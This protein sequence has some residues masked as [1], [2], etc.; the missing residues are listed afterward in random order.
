MTLIKSAQG[1]GYKTNLFFFWLKSPEEAILRIAD[2]VRNG[3][4]NI[5]DDVVRRRYHRGIVNFFSL[6]RHVVDSWYIFDSSNTVPELIA[7]GDKGFGDI[8]N[9]VEL[10]KQFKG[11]AN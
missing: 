3:G 9:N 2:R 5:P 11:Y 6:Y 8:I 4:H 10:W 7:R 1:L